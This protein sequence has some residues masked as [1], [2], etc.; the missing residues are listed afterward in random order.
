M[1]EEKSGFSITGCGCL[2]VILAALGLL[3]YVFCGH[4]F[5]ST[6]KIDTLRKTGKTGFEKLVRTYEYFQTNNLTL[7]DTSFCNTDLTI[8]N[9][10]VV[11]CYYNHL[12]KFKDKD[13]EAEG[14]LDFLD[15]DCIDFFPTDEE[16]NS[17]SSVFQKESS[18][19]EISKAN[20]IAIFFVE[21][22]EKPVYGSNEGFSGGHIMGKMILFDMDNQKPYCIKTFN[23]ISGDLVKFTDRKID[24]KDKNDHLMDELAEEMVLKARN[25]L[26][27]INGELHFRKN[28]TGRDNNL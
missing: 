14:D 4:W 21:S 19:E 26:S 6:E 3:F 12:K 27:Q 8:K 5:V 25:M 17:N 16:L 24:L 1:A 22:F 20:L 23:V 10:K 15:T 28:I 7:T 18:I 11:A 13:Y 2:L 9:T